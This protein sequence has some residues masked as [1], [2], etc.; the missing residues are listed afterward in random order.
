[1]TR[2]TPPRRTADGLVIRYA[3]ADEGAD[4]TVLS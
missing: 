1:M 4:E 3:E 2:M